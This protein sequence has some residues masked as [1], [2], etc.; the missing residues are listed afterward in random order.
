MFSIKDGSFK[1]F[2]NFVVKLSAKETKWTSLE[3]RRH[4]TFLE[5][6]ISTYDFGPVKL[7]SLSRNGSQDRTPIM[8]NQAFPCGSN[9]AA[10]LI[11]QT[12]ESSP[13]VELKGSSAPSYVAVVNWE[14]HVV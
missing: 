8:S 10:L 9:Y 1:S 2:E 7:P 4:L 12:D 6:L 14:Y 13:I 5:T 11:R 3:V